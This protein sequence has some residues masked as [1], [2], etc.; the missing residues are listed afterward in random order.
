MIPGGRYVWL[1][2]FL[3]RAGLIPSGYRGVARR[4]SGQTSSLAWASS[5]P[6]DTFPTLTASELR[7]LE[8]LAEGHSNAVIAANLGY[9]PKTI[10]NYVSIILAKL[11]V[12]D[13]SQAIVAARE[14]G[15]HHR[16]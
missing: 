6:S 3:P 1:E 11:G 9:S 14:A 16:P 10:R 7:V 12:E 4:C 2:T 5:E 8:Q 13:R 15:A